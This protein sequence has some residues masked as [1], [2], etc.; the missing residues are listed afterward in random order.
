MLSKYKNLDDVALHDILNR[1]LA[2]IKGADYSRAGAGQEYIDNLT[3]PLG[4]LGMLEEIAC[5]LYCLNAGSQPLAVDPALLFT[6]AADHGVVA[7]GVSS[8]AQ[9]VTR[10]MLLNFLA[11]GAG[12]NALCKSSGMGFLA[13]D[14]GVIG[15]DFPAQDKLIRAKIA[16]GTKNMVEGPAMT[17]REALLS[18]LLGFEL[19]ELAEK[20]GCKCIGAGEMG[21]GNTT[22]SSALYSV[23]LNLE[24]KDTVGAGA[25]LTGPGIAHKVKV[26]ER[27]L[28]RNKAAVESGDPV[29]VL[30]AVGGIEIGVMAGIMLGAARA[31]L[32][33]LVDGFIATA[34][35]LTAWKLCP[36]VQDACFFAHA[37]A[38]KA[39][40]RVL[41]MLGK[42][43]MLDLG[44]RLGEGT[45]AAIGLGVMRAA[46]NMFNNM[47]SFDSA[48]VTELEKG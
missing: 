9:E 12:I 37:S 40:A 5:N 13:V 29:E 18:L 39:H 27:A 3:K 10:Q 35:F 28:A 48:G 23:W 44:L 24:P 30:A 2:E 4:S 25:G 45:G 42:R 16:Q 34:S 6:I 36:K 14:A 8:A 38:E 41:E 7:E 22:P 15:P 21:I 1:L 26:V 43:P 31:S 47:A 46:V 33:M 32:P 19:A 17:R 11:D 20:Q